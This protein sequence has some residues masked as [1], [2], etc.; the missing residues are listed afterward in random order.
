M[1][2]VVDTK[3]KFMRVIGVILAFF[4]VYM[5]ISI[6][7]DFYRYNVFMNVD[8]SIVD[9]T[10]SYD[11]VVVEL[12]TY[13][14]GIFTA[15][16]VM[17]QVSFITSGG[18]IQPHKTVYVGNIKPGESKF[19]KVVLDLSDLSSVPKGYIVEVIPS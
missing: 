7:V 14:H 8:A 19:N 3:S 9:S 11:S 18:I 5:V 16:N 6:G 13:N 17:V 2:I 12:Q 1:V 10:V 4:I 15:R